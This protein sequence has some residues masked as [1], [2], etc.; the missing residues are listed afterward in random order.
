MWLNLKTALQGLHADLYSVGYKYMSDGKLLFEVKEDMKKRGVP[1]PDEGAT[2]WR[3]VSLSRTARHSRAA[4]ASIVKS[5]TGM[6]R[7]AARRRRRRSYQVGLQV[8][9]ARCPDL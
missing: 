8:S 7:L 1:S 9:R 2:R 3:S 6:I 4:M 5:N